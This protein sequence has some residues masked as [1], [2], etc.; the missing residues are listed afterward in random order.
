VS[1][2]ELWFS[3]IFFIC[4]CSSRHLS[5]EQRKMNEAI[6]L[7]S[8]KDHDYFGMANQYVAE[9]FIMFKD[10]ADIAGESG[11]IKQMHLTLT[12]PQTEGNCFTW[13]HAKPNFLIF[14]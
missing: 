11:S 2:K 3:F 13:L 8:V 14:D 7:F 1:S 6:I 5:D 10:L 4:K 9:S 12:R